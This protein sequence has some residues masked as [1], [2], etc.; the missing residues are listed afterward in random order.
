MTWEDMYPR[1]RLLIGKL[2]EGLIH[3]QTLSELVRCV[4]EFLASLIAA[5][6]MALCVSRPGPARGYD[7]LVARMLPA[8][9]D[10]APEWGGC[11]FVQDAVALHPNTVMRDE[12]MISREDLERNSMYRISHEMG[13]PLEQVMS[14]M[15]TVPGQTWHGGFTAYRTRPRPFSEREQGLLQYVARLLA[16]TIQ[17]C[18]MFLEGALHGGLF[19]SL[20]REQNVALLVLSPPSEIIKETA[21]V[22][23]LVSKWFSPKECAPSGIPRELLETCASLVERS[24]A[25]TW[26]RENEEA[27]ETLTVTFTPFTR[28]D[29][30]AYWQLKFQET[31]HPML[32]TWLKKLTPKETQIAQ[33]LLQGKSDKEIAAL[34][35]CEVGTVKK[36]L[37]SIY[38]KTETSGRAEFIAK[39]LKKPE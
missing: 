22:S 10:R 32:V 26:V 4:E 15:L 18:R 2:M 36:H 37:R 20:A 24:A 6:C 29:G 16:I 7:W 34:A 25:G 19:E 14:I 30:P 8:F 21:P 17:K 28:A 11:D 1:E 5:D 13:M 23:A 9:F 31:H 33:L 3:V 38:G 12:D 27:G 35:G 39:A